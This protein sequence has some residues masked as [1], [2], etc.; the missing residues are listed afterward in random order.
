MALRKIWDRK[1]PSNRCTHCTRCAAWDFC[2]GFVMCSE[3]VAGDEVLS[4]FPR[5]SWIKSW[6]SWTTD[7][8]HLSSEWTH[9][10]P[11][12]YRRKAGSSELYSQPSKEIQATLHG[13]PLL[14]CTQITN[15]DPNTHIQ[16]GK[17]TN[18]TMSSQPESFTVPNQVVHC[19]IITRTHTHIRSS[20]NRN[21][22]RCDRTEQCPDKTSYK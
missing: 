12:K 10:Q 6:K 4:G 3:E 11:F 2:P 7:R 21:L 17:R 14:Q 13:T 18:E 5:K 19:L 8:S 16:C 1:A 15:G 20:T 22:P 9:F